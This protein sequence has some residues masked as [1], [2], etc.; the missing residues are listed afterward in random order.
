MRNVYLAGS[1][2]GHA[3]PRH[4]RLDVARQ[5]QK[6]GEWNALDPLAIETANMTPQQTVKVDYEAILRSDA[7]IADVR[8]PSW[9]TA[10]EIAFAHA[11]RVPVVGWGNPYAP[12]SKWLTAHLDQF[13]VSPSEAI[14]ALEAYL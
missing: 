4:W 3:D 1:I 5:L 8:A 11:H 12:Q 9:G 6:L 2:F 13:V 7:V 14:I 10:M